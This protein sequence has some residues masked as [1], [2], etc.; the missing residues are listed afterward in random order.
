METRHRLNP[1]ILEH[2]REMRHPQTPA[3]ATVWRYVRN[4]AL[5]YKFRR[6][7]P[8]KRFIIDFY[9]AE[10]RLCVE[11]DGDTHIEEDQ[12][13]YDAARTEYLESIGRKVIRFTNDDVRYNINAVIQEMKDTCERLRQERHLRGIAPHPNPLPAGERGLEKT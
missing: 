12:Q 8:I 11:I 13:E 2:A 3:E 7:H 4:Q 10:L 5:G 1:I 6:Q 9:C